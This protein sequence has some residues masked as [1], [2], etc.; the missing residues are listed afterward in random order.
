MAD[1]KFISYI[2]VSTQK[3]GASGLG[4][5]AQTAAVQAYLEGA[6]CTNLIGEYVEVESAKGSNALE[7]RPQLRAAMQHC[8]KTR[9]TLLIAKLDRLARDVHF[10]SG[11]IKEGVDFVCADMPRANK[12][13]LQMYSVMAEWER[14]QI[15]ARTKA[16]L[17][18][19]RARGV[20]LGNTRNL[21]AN[22]AKRSAAASTFASR[23]DG[24]VKGMKLRGMTQWEMVNELNEIGITAPRGGKWGLHQLQRLLKRQSNGANPPTAAFEPPALAEVRGIR[25][26]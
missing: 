12:V 11:L 23:L 5:E 18:A 25:Q 3:Q 9:S 21:V 4:L 10:I 19:A 26:G 14:D 13:M 15:S 8:R 16:A 6:G 2:R 7:L 24:T 17:A 20:V 1:G 22:A